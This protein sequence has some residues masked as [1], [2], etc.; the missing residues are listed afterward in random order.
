MN[1]QELAQKTADLIDKSVAE[2]MELLDSMDADQMIN[3]TAAV[4]DEDTVTI[5]DILSQVD[6]ENQ[7]ASDEQDE[8]ASVPELKKRI[9]SLGRKQIKDQEDMTDVWSLIGKLNP[10]DWK[11]VWP[12][13]DSEILQALYQEATDK[14]KTDISASD[15]TMLHDYARSYVKE[16]VVMYE[17]EMWQVQIPRAPDNL[18]GIRNAQHLIM[19][20]RKSLQSLHEHVLG[21]T[22]MPSLA[23]VKE[24]AGIASVD[25]RQVNLP[26]TNSYVKPKHDTDSDW[27]KELR[28][29]IHEI[30]K[31][32]DEPETMDTQE[33]IQLH[34]K[35]LARKA[36]KVADRLK[37]T[38]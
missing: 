21:M 9:Q 27:L 36:Q 31:L 4:D 30:E 37:D 1:T 38:K 25:N 10:D 8:Q 34:M 16:S 23:R 22:A 18:V 15:A 6:V 20:P 11:L 3:L 2:I 7:E 19:V 33:E 13:L 32:H 26:M 35:A 14:D 12:S 28:M 29:H 5:D 24:L 17:N